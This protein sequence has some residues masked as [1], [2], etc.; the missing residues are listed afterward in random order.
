MPQAS[1]SDQPVGQ[2]NRVVGKGDCMLT[3][4]QGTGFFWETL[5]NLPENKALKDA[6]GDPNVL[7]E[8]DLVTI[9]EPR[10][11]TE[12]GATEQRHRFR[13]RG[14]PAK[15]K[16]RLQQDGKALSGVTCA[17]TFDQ[18]QGGSFD[19]DGDGFVE[20]QVPIAARSGRLTYRH[21]DSEMS[22]ELNFGHLDPPR[23]LTG[24]AQRLEHLGFYSGPMGEQ[25]AAEDLAPAVAAFQKAN[26]LEASGKADDATCDK[27]KEAHGS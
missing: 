26:G 8:G 9:P 6:R 21:E 18:G 10:P 2:G 11:R 23:T 12:Q 17:V 5:W 25:V 1:N 4:A 7:R 22:Y 27:L 3:I 24:V 14:I 15:V 13:R 16:I 20:F 19:S